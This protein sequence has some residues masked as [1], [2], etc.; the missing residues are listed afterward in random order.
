MLGTCISWFRTCHGRLFHSLTAYIS[1]FR[2]CQFPHN[3][4]ANKK[5]EWDSWNTGGCNRHHCLGQCHDRC[6]K[7][8]VNSFATQ[9]RTLQELQ[10]LP[11]VPPLVRSCCD[12]WK[13]DHTLW[14]WG[15]CVTHWHMFFRINN[16]LNIYGLN[17]LLIV[18]SHWLIRKR[19]C[20]VNSAQM[21][22]LGL[23]WHICWTNY[24]FSLEE[25]LVW[26]ITNWLSI[27]TR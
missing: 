16:R 15:V 18:H 19:A 10:I 21:G 14:K 3:T 6:K 12:W 1:W 26:Q 27:F 4:V 23:A 9:L 24:W 13:S 8:L 22:T 2:S 5:R 7:T 20:Q 25:E 11:Q 17:W